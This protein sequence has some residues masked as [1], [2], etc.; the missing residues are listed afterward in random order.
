MKQ[1]LVEATGDVTLIGRIVRPWGPE[2]LKVRAE[3]LDTCGG[4][5][6]QSWGPGLQNPQGGKEH[7]VWRDGW[8]RW[9][10]Q[11]LVVSTEGEIIMPGSLRGCRTGDKASRSPGGRAGR[12]QR[13][14]L[15]IVF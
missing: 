2:S 10:Q 9:P 12:C 7:G 8:G 11:R 1:G 3:E 13:I 6:G 4:K 14:S 5:G 15:R